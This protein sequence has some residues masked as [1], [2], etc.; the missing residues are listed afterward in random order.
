MFKAEFKYGIVGIRYGSLTDK[1]GWHHIPKH[2]N[3]SQE[4]MYTI[5]Q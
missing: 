5:Y 2:K 4:R 3:M 1:A